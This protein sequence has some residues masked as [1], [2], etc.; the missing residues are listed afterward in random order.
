MDQKPEAVGG[1]MCGEVRYQ[2]IGA[3][4]HIGYCHCR[5]CRHHGGAAVAGMLV[6]KPEN[7]RFTNGQ[8]ST[9]ESS[10]GIRRG[11]CRRCGTSLTWEG[12]GLISIH[13]GTLDDP[14]SFPPTLHWRYEERASWFEDAAGLPHVLMEF[15]PS[16]EDTT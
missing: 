3:P 5:S 4:L 7:V 13:I 15:P 16:D 2:G 8:I 11:F 14:D 10:S 1:C 9:Y 12:H 6:F